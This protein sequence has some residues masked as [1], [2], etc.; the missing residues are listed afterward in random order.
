M[1][2]NADV[3]IRRQSADQK[4]FW[5]ASVGFPFIFGFAKDLRVIIAFPK[6]LDWSIRGYYSR[7]HFE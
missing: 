4:L 5:T 3:L 7:S 6:I 1:A 2:I